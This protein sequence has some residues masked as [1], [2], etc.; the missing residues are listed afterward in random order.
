MNAYS[1]RA[2]RGAATMSTSNADIKNYAVC[3]CLGQG[4]FV[5]GGSHGNAW[6]AKWNAVMGTLIM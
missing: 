6:I 5:R 3:S 4:M 1:E 2:Y